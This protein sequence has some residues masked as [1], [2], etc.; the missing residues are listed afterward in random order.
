MPI[1]TRWIKVAAASM[2]QTPLDWENN[3][4]NIV[5]AIRDARARNV[6]FSLPVICFLEI[7][8]HAQT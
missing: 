8:Y 2:N 5:A 6:H 1:S 7:V 4:A 3:R